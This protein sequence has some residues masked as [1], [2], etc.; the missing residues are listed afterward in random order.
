VLLTADSDARVGDRK[1]RFSI[2]LASAMLIVN[3]VGFGPTLYLRA[4]FDPPPIPAYLYAHGALGTA[5]FVLVLVQTL[6][7]ANRRLVAHRMLGWI[8]AAVAVGVLISGIVTSANMVPRN[9]ALGLTSEADIALY[10]AVTAADNAAFIVF[11]T[12]VLLG[13]LFRRRRDIHMRFMLLSAASILGPAAARIGSWFGP[14]P[15]PVTAALILGCLLAF[16][17]HDVWSRRRLHW[18]TAV[19]VALFVGLTVGMRLSGYGAA[20]VEQRLQEAQST[21]VGTP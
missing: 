15:N 2:G 14:I 21:S 20:L 11:P 16:V 17:V 4:L 9:V 3:L 1:S 7:V 12:L 6:L 19:G 10:E 5:W 13:V 18:A 8:G